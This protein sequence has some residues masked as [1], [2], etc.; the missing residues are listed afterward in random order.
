MNTG[1]YMQKETGIEHFLSFS[2]E[3]QGGFCKKFYKTRHRFIH[4]LRR[5]LGN[6]PSDLINQT[7]SPSNDGDNLLCC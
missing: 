5:K 3:G 6:T 2:K 1:L 4:P 7:S